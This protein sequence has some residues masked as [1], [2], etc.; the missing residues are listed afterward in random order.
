[1]VIGLFGFIFLILPIAALFYEGYKRKGIK[2][3]VLNVLYFGTFSTL[4]I[5]FTMYY[6]LNFIMLIPFFFILFFFYKYKN[7]KK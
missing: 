2:Q 3:G 5:I 4:V 1:M 6:G 7:K